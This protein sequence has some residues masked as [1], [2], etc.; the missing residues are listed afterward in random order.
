[1]HDEVR[2]VMVE[3]VRDAVED[4][5]DAAGGVWSPRTTVAASLVMGSALFLVLAAV[6][7]AR[8]ELLG[9]NASGHLVS[10]LVAVAALLA[11]AAWARYFSESWVVQVAIAVAM[12]WGYIVG[13]S[14]GELAGL[15]GPVTLMVAMAL[16]ALVAGGARGITVAG[17]GHAAAGVVLLV[18]AVAVGAAELSDVDVDQVYRVL[19]VLG[20]LVTGVIPR[21]SLSVGGLASADYRVR[22][23]GRMSLGTLRSRFRQSN[24]ILVGALTGIGLVVVW[25]CLHLTFGEDPWDRYLALGLGLAALLRSRVYSRTHHMVPLRTVGVAVL[26]LQL[27]RLCA[28]VDALGAWVTAILVG[29]VVL[30]VG[31]STLPMSVITR[32]RVKRILNIVEFLVVIELIVLVFGATGVIAKLGGLV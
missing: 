22:H 26:A 15:D 9:T 2:P 4:S 28:D 16:A 18:A 12:V 23:V 17:T 5:A 21:L 19:P 13:L 3:D 25:A 31:V 1:Q 27:V 29:A 11:M 24:A 14:L 6:R 20:L 8:P 7:Y 30:A 32:A 10:A